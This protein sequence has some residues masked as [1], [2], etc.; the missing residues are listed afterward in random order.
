MQLTALKPTADLFCAYLRNALKDQLQQGQMKAMKA[1][2]KTC[3]SE[4]LM[5]GSSPILDNE[6]EDGS[7]VETQDDKGAGS[8]RTFHG[9]LG[10]QFKFPGDAKK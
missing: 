8:V 10:L 7:L 2:V 4:T 1:F 9:G 6:R 3:Y 5:I